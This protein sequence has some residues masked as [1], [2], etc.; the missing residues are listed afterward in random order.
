MVY[1]LLTFKINQ[2]IN[3][4][5]I[6]N[7]K[8]LFILEKLSN[9]YTKL[10]VLILI[11]IFS[12]FTYSKQE[13]PENKTKIIVHYQKSEDKN[14]DL[15][16]WP[17]DMGGKEY[18]F[19]KKDKFGE[20]AEI[21]LDGRFDKVGFIVRIPDWSKKD[22]D[23]DRYID[24]KDGFA[25]VWLKSGD[26][27]VYTTNI[28]RVLKPEKDKT[29][30]LI[31]YQKS[32]DKNW[33]LWIWPKGL[34]GKE[35]KFDDVDSF[36]LISEIV[37]DGNYKEVGY[38]VRTPDWSSK[39]ADRYI[40]VENG[41]AEVWLK[42]KDPK[43]YYENPD[44]KPKSYDK[45]SAVVIYKRYKKDYSNL[46]LKI[47]GSK[48]VFNFKKV[49][50]YAKA[51]VEISGK[52]LQKLEF[53]IFSINKKKIISDLDTRVITKFD[54]KGHATVYINQDD[55]TVYY[56]K[57][58]ADKKNEILSA[59]I[60][61]LNSITIETNKPFSLP[62]QIKV[63][64]KK[65]K[66]VT[67]VKGNNIQTNK[68]KVVFAKELDLF[69]NLTV[70]LENF[71]TK[72][73]ILGRVV[74]SKSFDEKFSYDK[75]LGAM[76]TENSTTFKVWA[77]TATKV[78]LLIYGNDKKVK[79]TISM[80]KEEK[81]VYSVTL[82]ENQLGTIYNYEV[83][84]GEKSNIAVDPYAKSTTVNGEHS[85]VVNPK[86]SDI[87]F[88]SS[89]NPII[90]ELHVRDL[91]SY[92][93]SGI[94]N[95]G[96]FLG[97]TEKGTKTKD[98]QITGLDYI[99]SL[100]VTHVQLLPIYDFSKYSVDENNQ[101]E[102]YNWGYDPVNYNTPE[103]SY[104]TNPNNPNTRI[105][106]LQ[107]LVD[108]LHKNNIAVIMDVVYNHVFSVGEHSFDKIVPNYFFRHN[109]D[110]TLTNGTGVGN[111]VASERAMAR[112]FIV[113]SV[114]YWASTYNLDGFRFDLMGI[115]DVETMK[116]V[117]DELLKINPNI[118]ILGEGWD[119]G[120]LPKEEKAAQYNANKLDN[121]AFFNDDIRD[122]VKGSTFG[123]IGKGFASGEKN[124]EQRVLNNIKGG[125]GIKTYIS[126]NQLI[127][128]VEAHDNLT[129]WDQ[130]EKTNS[131]ES[132][133]V[134]IKRHKLASSIVLLSEG[135]PFIHAGQEFA[136]TKQGNENSYNASDEINKLD[137]NRAK[138]NNDIVEYIKELIAIRKDYDLFNLSD[139]KKI[140]KVFKTI[141]AQ[142][143]VV[144]YRLSDDKN[145]IYVIHNASFNEKEINIEN[146]K[147]IVLVKDNKANAN[148]IEK[149]NVKNSKI[150]I[151][152][153]S[154]L[155]IKKV[156]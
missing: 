132:V 155:V 115:L 63:G 85:V 109:E 30:L 64:N 27:K 80:K 69:E 47:T 117:R 108:E 131:D 120:T 93:D 19:T 70:K 78:N 94:K 86:P 139:Y 99:K 97:L 143:Q 116:T 100:G 103:G 9:Y 125:E 29:K 90:Y 35:Y 76:Y 98:G 62:K 150:K 8:E 51:E 53:S 141:V 110:G 21:E 18:K 156:N 72:K 34:D 153:I 146:G 13:I 61:D 26:E 152:P 92:S 145:N 57:E 82:D 73:V 68:I 40:K 148:G 149:I 17:K 41:V 55:K 127:Q 43:T 83:Y 25:E 3:Y 144:A 136:R 12:I 106:E 111:D 24:V 130:L 142:D 66:S 20:V 16:I 105:K 44:A 113:D 124:L 71:G 74:E 135:I 4:Y 32:E 96:K 6:Y 10:I 107:Q 138:E 28:D 1:F 102:K 123:K 67:V 65:I 122:A 50:D 154:T 45:L 31:H 52:D 151:S 56:S 140:N 48:K 133:Q 84:F 2:G 37:L 128:Y 23:K 81:G 7:K 15:W 112:K 119:M 58:K 126:A 75:E 88:T 39:T 129:L 114:K 59:T 95:K 33:D 137:W 14:W 79:N 101:F 54:D 147:Y 121:I 46:K 11:S 104:S 87:K 49:K 134:R 38:I 22:V 42:S 60:D 118:I 77:P 89:K 36:G 5:A 91:S